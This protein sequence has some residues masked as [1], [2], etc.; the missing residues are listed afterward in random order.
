MASM[1]NLFAGL[2]PSSQAEVSN[3][4]LSGAGISLERIVSQG[5]NS[6]DGFWYD[7]D[8]AEWVMVL[9]GNA[10]LTI[11]GEKNDRLLGPGD[12]VFLPAHCRHRVAWTTPDAPTVWLALFIDP[13]LRPQVPVTHMANGS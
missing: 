6:P 5:H 11:E 2:P 9:T 1:E 12:A 3:K 8:R 4:L 13:S 7:Q 10:R